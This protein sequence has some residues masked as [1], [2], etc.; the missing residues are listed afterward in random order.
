MDLDRNQARIVI[1][2]LGA[3]GQPPEYGFQFFTAGLDPYLDVLRDEYLRTYIRDDGSTFKLALGVYGGGKT[4]FLFC[5]RDIAWQEGFAA[6]YVSLSAGASPF[7]KL[8]LVYAAIIQ[9]LVPPLTP[10]ELLSGHESGIQAFIDRWFAARYADALQAG[11]DEEGTRAT[12]LASLDD[13]EGIENI[14]FRRA[15]R[16]AFEA[17]LDHRDTDFLDICQWLSGEGYVAATHQEVR[18]PPEDRSN[19]RHSR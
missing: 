19:H 13:L 2:R 3:S 16:S 11:L 14:S 5:L 9:G 18:D 1:E 10:D 17:K 15:V 4:H 8:E 7:H 6:S 12:M